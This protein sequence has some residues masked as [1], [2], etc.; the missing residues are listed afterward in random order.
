MAINTCDHDLGFLGMVLRSSDFDPL[1]NG[2]PFAPPIDPGPAPINVTGTASQITEVVRLC[3]DDKVKIH[4]P[5][6][7]FALF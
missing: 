3:K 4:H 5:T 7:N 1:N 2:N 6:V